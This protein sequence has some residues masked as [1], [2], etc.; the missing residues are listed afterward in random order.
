M[1]EL[2]MYIMGWAFELYI[3]A[4]VLLIL[5]VVAGLHHV[6]TR[7]G[8]DTSLGSTLRREWYVGRLHIL[9]INSLGTRL[10]GINRTGRFLY[11]FMGQRHYLRFAWLLPDEA[12]IQKAAYKAL[13]KAPENDHSAL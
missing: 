5:A 13:L 7:T 4:A 3:A 6:A 2:D 11:V 10:L 8:L 12:R 9:W 1:N